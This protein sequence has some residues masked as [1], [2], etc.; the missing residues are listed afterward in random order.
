M[1]R[2]T[3]EEVQFQRAL[4]LM[5]DEHGY[6]EALS[7]LERLNASG[8]NPRHLM[9]L[10]LSLSNSGRGKEAISAIRTAL[11]I[12]PKY[13]EGEARLLLAQCLLSDGDKAGAIEQ[14][15]IVATMPPCGTAYGSIPDEAIH[16][17]KRYET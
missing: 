1:S 11:S 16:M 3:D 6:R 17:L 8:D 5:F 13:Q 12:R 7:I 10:A 9:A 4:E 14:W 2:A 15:K